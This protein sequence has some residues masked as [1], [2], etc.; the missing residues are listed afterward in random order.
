MVNAI[1]MMKQKYVGWILIKGLP[2]V[3]WHE[4]PL[5]KAEVF[6]VGFRRWT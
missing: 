6:V 3:L 4:N 5:K 1:D 2:F